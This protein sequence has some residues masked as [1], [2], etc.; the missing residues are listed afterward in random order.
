MGKFHFSGIRQVEPWRKPLTQDPV[1]MLMAL[2]KR[3][4]G[5]IRYFKRDQMRQLM[6]ASG[7][8]ARLLPH[9]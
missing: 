7:S 6:M 2:D 1:F 3:L 9:I 4:G 5:H 8:Q